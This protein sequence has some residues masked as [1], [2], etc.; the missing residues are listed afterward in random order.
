MKTFQISTPDQTILESLIFKINDLTKPKGSLGTLEDIATQIGLIQQTLHPELHKPHGI[1]F[2]ADHGIVD[3]GVSF[4]PKEVTRQMISNFLGGG[5]GINFLA[6]QH[7]FVLKVVDGGIDYDFPA[8]DGLISRKVRKGTRNFLYKSALTDLEVEQCIE[9]GAEIVKE[10]HKEGCNIICF[11][12]MGIG[13][14]SPSSMWMTCLAGIPLLECVGAGS[15][16]DSRGVMHKYT[17]L[18]RALDN[19]KEERNAMNV[20]RYFGGIEM[21]MAVGGMLQAAELNM[22]ILVDGFIMT[23]CVLAAS[24]LYPEVINYCVFG[25]QG[26]EAGHKLLLDHLKVKPL[27]NLGLRLGEGSG[28]ICAYPIVES[29][30]RMINE[31]NTFSNAA[32]T[33]YF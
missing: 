14:T 2:A 8:I 33:K 22:I 12:E 19:F 31:M 18:K 9:I 5:A 3:E 20:M 16:L 11:G 1:I 7:N 23:N 30:V 27:L 15:G 25:H 28:A 21:I 10:C 26:D 32:V 29:A 4:S 13:N 6:R 17:I 24:K